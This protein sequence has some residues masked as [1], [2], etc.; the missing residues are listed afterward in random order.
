MAERQA[1]VKHC[2]EK[3]EHARH[4]WIEFASLDGRDAS[5]SIFEKKKKKNAVKT[6]NGSRKGTLGIGSVKIKHRN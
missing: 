4:D 1:K 2:E 3:P 5:I 6:K